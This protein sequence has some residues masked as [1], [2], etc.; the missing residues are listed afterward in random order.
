EIQQFLIFAKASI[1]ADILSCA[2]ANGDVVTGGQDIAPGEKLGADLLARANA[3][4]EQAYVLYD[5]PAGVTVRAL[6]IVRDDANTVV[7]GYVMVGTVL[8]QSFL[9]AIQSNS[10]S[11][12]AI[13]WRGQP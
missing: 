9:Q 6:S 12:I 10:D 8:D 13:L 2:D 3:S 4:P 5:E 11:Q 7:L 1:G